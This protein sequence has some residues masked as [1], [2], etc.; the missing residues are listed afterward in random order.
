MKIINIAIASFLICTSICCNHQYNT[1][2][3]LGSWY[4]DTLDPLNA[5]EEVK[6]TKTIYDSTQQRV[7]EIQ[8]II[9]IPSSAAGKTFLQ[10]IKVEVAVR[11][12]RRMI[13]MDTNGDNNLQDE[14]WY[15]IDEDVPMITFKNVKIY[16]G[17]TL[18]TMTILEGL[19]KTYLSPQRPRLT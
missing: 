16:D 7:T 15:K 10:P 11:N 8:G 9:D 18:R 2:L 19:C 17:D 12:N 1:I 5:Y 14:Y 13:K 6:A 4:T 3:T